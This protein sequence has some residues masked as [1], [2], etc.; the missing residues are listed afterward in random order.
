MSSQQEICEQA[1]LI[2]AKGSNA[3]PPQ[4]DFLLTKL[5]ADEVKIDQNLFY[6]VQKW[7]EEYLKYPRERGSKF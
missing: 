4:F 5:N 3:R 6:E 7:L 2:I 1:I